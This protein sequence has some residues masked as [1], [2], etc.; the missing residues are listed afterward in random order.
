MVKRPHASDDEGGSPQLV[1]FF[2]KAA[3]FFMLAHKTLE[4]TN[5]GEVVVQ[6]RI[7]GRSGVTVHPISPMRRER[8]PKRA[9]SQEGYR[10]ERDQC[11]FCSEVRDYRHDVYDVQSR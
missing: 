11:Q 3:I 4:L 8:V 10:R 7:H 9:G 5:A 6:E 2:V 1:T